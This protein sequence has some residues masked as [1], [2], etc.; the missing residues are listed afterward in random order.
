MRLYIPSAS[1]VSNDKN[2]NPKLSSQ[3]YENKMCWNASTREY[4]SKHIPS[5][6]LPVIIFLA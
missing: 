3:Y 2:D 1:I 5:F 6:H 4:E